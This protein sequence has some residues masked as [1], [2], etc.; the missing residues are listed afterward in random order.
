MA[1][2]TGAVRT[3]AA[4]AAALL[5]AFVVFAWDAHAEKASFEEHERQLWVLVS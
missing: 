1:S 2:G 4:D 5:G 3:G